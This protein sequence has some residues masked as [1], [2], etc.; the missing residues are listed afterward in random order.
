MRE[1][2][3]GIKPVGAVGEASEQVELARALTRVV[4]TCAERAGTH[5][6]TDRYALYCALTADDDRLVSELKE[7]LMR[8]LGRERP[9]KKRQR[10]SARV[11][12]QI[13]RAANRG[14]PT[15]W[16]N[17]QQISPAAAVGA[18]C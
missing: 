15:D 16:P 14:V 17:E 9:W 4:H 6:M 7:V 2:S 10:D 1:S 12:P 18:T 3:S 11:E 8:H 13:R 5:A